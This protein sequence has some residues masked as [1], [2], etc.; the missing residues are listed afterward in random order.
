VYNQLRDMG[1]QVRYDGNVGKATVA[2]ILTVIVPAVL[3]NLLTGRGPKD[4]ENAL[5]WA[6]KHSLLFAADTVPILRSIASAMEGGHDV[7]F[8]PVEN[9]MQKGGKAL[10]E[11]ASP[12][13]DKD[14]LG[15]GLDAAEFAGEVS[16]V[17][18]SHQVVKTGRYIKR[19]SEG[20]VQN[21]T[22]WKAIVGGH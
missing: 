19:A 20:K 1:H 9:V 22:V 21:P 10:M 2:G 13:E 4:D 5:W 11:A 15:V 12:K 14:W 16:G 17:P 18:G 6:A 8:S 7:Q 3:G